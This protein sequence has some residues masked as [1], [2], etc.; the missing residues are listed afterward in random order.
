MTA[1]PPMARG[2]AGASL[3]PELLLLRVPLVEALDATTGV[4]E[5]LLARVERVALRAQLHAELADG[6]AGHELVATR[7]VHLALGVR[8]VGVGLHDPS[9]LG[10]MVVT[11]DNAGVFRPAG[12]TGATGPGSGPWRSRRGIR[13]STWS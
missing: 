9:S 13:R 11:D 12:R 1:W 8:G 3:T 10:K 6:R 7:A 2:G 4:H 5:L